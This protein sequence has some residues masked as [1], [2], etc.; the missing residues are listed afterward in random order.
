[1]GII[2]VVQSLK[3]SLQARRLEKNLRV[4]EALKL[5]FYDVETQSPIT[6]HYLA[7]TSLI[8]EGKSLIFRLMEPIVT[9][10]TVPMMEALPDDARRKRPGKNVHQNF[11]LCL[12]LQLLCILVLISGFHLSSAYHGYRIRKSMLSQEKRTI[13]TVT[14]HLMEV[15][16]TRNRRAGSTA[17]QSLERRL[18]RRKAK[19]IQMI[20]PIQSPVI[21][22]GA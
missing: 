16:R 18:K 6:K 20:I 14:A 7:S 10:T 9:P 4:W 12:I 11:K 15:K 22:S 2:N 8:V 13:P 21:T 17:S 5:S 19:S 1:M 3:M